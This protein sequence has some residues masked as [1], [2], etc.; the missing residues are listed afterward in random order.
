MIVVANNVLCGISPVVLPL[1]RE[2]ER[3]RERNGVT[4]RDYD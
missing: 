4:E 2:R 1:R 3:E